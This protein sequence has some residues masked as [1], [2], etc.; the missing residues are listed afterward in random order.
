MDFGTL[1]DRAERICAYA[2][3]RVYSAEK[4][5]VAILLGCDDG[6]RVWLNSQLIHE[7]PASRMAAPDQ[8]AVP[9]TLEAGWNT[10][11]VKV[12]NQTRA[13]A[14][15]L[16]LSGEPADLAWASCS[17]VIARGRRDEAERALAE[18]LAKQPDHAPTR[19]RAERFY[20][21]CGDADAQRGE[22]ARVAADYAQLLKLRPDDHTLWYWAGTVLAELDDAVAY[23]KHRRAMLERFGVTEDPTIAERT[24]K[25]CLLLPAEANE[26]KRMSALAELAVTKGIGRIELP[27]FHLVRGLAEYRRGNRDSAEEWLRKALSAQRDNWSLTVTAHLIQVMI[28]KQRGKPREAKESL[29][30]AVALFDRQAPKPGSPSYPQGW[31]D[32]LI[33]QV[34]RR[35]AEALLG[36]TEPRPKK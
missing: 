15:S 34:L 3:M 10:L 36:G 35:E 6:V 11:L 30:R 29:T 7:N 14:L 24:A 26:L 16:R 1:F 9:A 25:V 21:Q 8:D 20:R 13:H 28:Q 4:Q 22:W 19:T 31:H 18:I 23:R 27:Y 32:R 17:A 33:C 2:Q 12:V 5:R